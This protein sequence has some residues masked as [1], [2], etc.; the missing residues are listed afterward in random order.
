M[1]EYLPWLSQEAQWEPILLVLDGYPAHRTAKIQQ[2]AREPQIEL[3]SV[4]AGGTSEFQPFDRRSFGELKS[5]A[6]RAFE[7][8]AWRSGDRR[9]TPEQA[10]A[11]L[12][13]AWNSI[14]AGS[15]Q[16]AWELG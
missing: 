3:L 7:H 16:R 4:P 10:I 1:L 9:S 6:R 12:V 2:R 11:V 8:L 15:I 14:A 5:Q 13:E